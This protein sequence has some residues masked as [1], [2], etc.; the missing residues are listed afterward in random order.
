[1]SI[2]IT[3]DA[4]DAI[5]SMEGWENF[6]SLVVCSCSDSHERE[7]LKDLLDRFTNRKG[8]SSAE[9]GVLECILKGIVKSMPSGYDSHNG[10][11]LLRGLY[12][13][14]FGGI[15][16]RVKGGMVNEMVD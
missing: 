10:E 7:V 11:E 4:C 6:C 12:R 2:K 15:E 16:M 8:L 13:G 3:F 1:M 9:C 5:W 14:I